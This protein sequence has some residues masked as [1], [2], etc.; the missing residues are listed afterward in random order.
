[1]HRTLSSYKFLSRP[2]SVLNQTLLCHVWRAPIWSGMSE[3]CWYVYMKMHTNAYIVQQMLEMLLTAFPFAVI[4]E[5]WQWW[6][7][8][9]VWDDTSSYAVIVQVFGSLLWCS[10]N[11]RSVWSYWQRCCECQLTRLHQTHNPEAKVKRLIN[12]IEQR[13]KKLSASSTVSSTNLLLLYS[14]FPAF[15]LFPHFVPPPRVRVYP[16]VL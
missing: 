9:I 3:L 13:E 7:V 2:F 8:K 5:F 4:H 15:F 16:A 14:S 12:K 11:E 6:W 10:M 1:M